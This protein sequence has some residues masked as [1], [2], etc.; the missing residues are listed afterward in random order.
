MKII[1]III[2]FLI[3]LTLF[4]LF[5]YVKVYYEK[6]GII[7]ELNEKETQIVQLNRLKEA[8]SIQLDEKNNLITQKENQLQNLLK[9]LDDKEGKLAKVEELLNKTQRDV[10]DLQQ[11]IETLQSQNDSLVKE[12]ND[13]LEKLDKLNQDYSVLLSRWQSIEE[14]RK[15]IIQLKKKRYLGR[16][17]SIKTE[18][19]IIEGN[20][21]YIIKDGIS[22]LPSKVKIKVIP[23]Q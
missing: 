9:E 8:L 19:K 13:L 14:L 2:A 23:A 12:R 4:S 1:N 5:Q 6:E 17:R 3:G 18:N 21:G 22:T 10:E 11:K 20:R 7:K 16:I 15:A